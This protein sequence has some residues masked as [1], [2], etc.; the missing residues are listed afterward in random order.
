MLLP[1]KCLFPYTRPLLMYTPSPRAP[2]LCV[3]PAQVFSCPKCVPSLHMP[4]AH[5]CPCS[6]HVPPICTCSTHALFPTRPIPTH[7]LFS[8]CLPLN[9]SLS[10][11]TPHTSGQASGAQ[12]AA[13][14]TLP[15]W[16]RHIS[17]PSCHMLPAWGGQH[18]AQPGHGRTQGTPRHAGPPPAAPVTAD[19]VQLPTVPALTAGGRDAVSG[20]VAVVPGLAGAAGGQGGAAVVLGLRNVPAAPVTAVQCIGALPA[21]TGRTGCVWHRDMAPAPCGAVWCLS[22]AGAGSRAG[23]T[24]GRGGSC[25]VCGT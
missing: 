7:P 14:V 17:H 8:C 10:H 24:Y 11:L 18:R 22:V 15:S 3:T 16:Q 2:S 4:P 6:M 25:R 20:A 13:Q 23:G 12:P 9:V 21:L 19:L 5:A 1:H